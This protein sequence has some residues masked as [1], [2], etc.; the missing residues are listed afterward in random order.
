MRPPIVVFA[1]LVHFCTV[2]Q[3]V[4]F[5]RRSPVVRAVERIGPAVVNIWT[6]QVVEQ[7]TQPFP[8][9]RDPFFDEFF[10]DFLEPQRTRR[11]TRTSLGSGVIVRSDG[12]VLTNE[13]VLLRGGRIR[14]TLADE[15]EFEASLVGTDS[16]SDLAVLKVDPDGPLP[17]APMGDS[18]GILI[19]ETVIAI[20]N[21]FGLSHTVTTG[22]VSAL[23]RSLQTDRQTYYDF[24]QTDASINPGNSG[25]PLLNVDGE[26]IG[27]NTAIYQKAQG[28]GFAIPANRAR[29]IVDDLILYGEVHVPWVGAVVQNLTDQLADHFGVS[30]RRGVLVRGVEEA[31]PASDAGVKAGD[32]ILAV[33]D[34]V[35]HSSDEYEQR[36]RDHAADSEVRLSLHR[37]GGERSVTV[38]SRPFPLERAEGLA[39]S[40]L[41]LRLGQSRQALAVTEVRQGSNA[42]RIGIQRGDLLRAVGGTPVDTLDALRRRMVEVRNSQSVLLSIQRGRRLYRLQVPV[43]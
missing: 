12:Y 37:D 14:V 23:G 5:S 10:R 6:E 41:G 29:R 3:A 9:F 27:V 26:L 4:D 2:F 34:R 13:H 8:G 17:I 42:A 36:I 32:V 33:G 25:G 1:L 15:R 31:S 30:R 28:I 18:D 35:V 40:L 24:I 22:V 20:G 7:Q 16:D 19:G 11:R 38:Q 39:W 21:P 43:G